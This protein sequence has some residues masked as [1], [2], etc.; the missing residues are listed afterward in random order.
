MTGGEMSES[1]F[2]GPGEVLLA[3]EIWGDIFPIVISPNQ[4]QPWCI[5]KGSHLASTK[6]VVK[7]IK[8]QGAKQ[9]FCKCCVEIQ[10]PS[11]DNAS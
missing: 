1:T 9:S 3:P 10:K 4:T 2:T 7:T 8:S 6:D 5:G 11:P